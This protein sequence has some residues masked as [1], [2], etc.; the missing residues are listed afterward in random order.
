MSYVILS[1]RK[2]KTHKSSNTCTGNLKIP[3][4]PLTSCNPPNQRGDERARSQ[5]L[6]YSHNGETAHRKCFHDIN[7]SLA[8]S[9]A[10]SVS[11]GAHW[12]AFARI[13]NPFPC[14]TY[15]SVYPLA[16]RSMRIRYQSLRARTGAGRALLHKKKSLGETHMQFIK[17]LLNSCGLEYKCILFHFLFPLLLHLLHG[18]SSQPA[19]D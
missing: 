14:A 11:V 13:W 9:R 17:R 5:L 10:S 19:A 2:T 6:A 12:I 15:L 8:C 3:G 1:F 16:G 4:I 7:R 18:C